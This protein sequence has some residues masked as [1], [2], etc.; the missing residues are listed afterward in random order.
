MKV[1]VGLGND[2]KKYEKTR[3]NAGFVWI[4]KLYSVFNQSSIYSVS[5]WDKKSK[6]SSWISEIRKENMIS[7][8]VKLDGI[9]VKPSTFMNNSGVAVRDLCKVYKP[10]FPDDL[11]IVHDDLDIP[12]GSFKIQKAVGPKEHNGILSINSMVGINYLRIR[13]GI[14]GRSAEDPY[15][16]PSSD[17]VLSDF[18]EAEF[19]LLD[20]AIK[21][22][23]ELLLNTYEI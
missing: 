18:S 5:S 20:S 23:I 17:Y 13:L 1:I 4:D 6:F 7:G 16:I 11:I 12:I 14:D 2:G 22:S 9:L 19:S 3:H 10:S 15:K 21:S 8:E